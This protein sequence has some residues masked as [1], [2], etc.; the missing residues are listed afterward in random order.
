MYS[1]LKAAPTGY[2]YFC[3][4]Y[5]RQAG[6]PAQGWY[7][8]RSNSVIYNKKVYRIMPGPVNQESEGS[9]KQNL[10][11]HAKYDHGFCGRTAE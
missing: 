5:Q 9:V 2:Q 4:I 7:I 3:E 8:L 6:S 10:L 11:M 1:R